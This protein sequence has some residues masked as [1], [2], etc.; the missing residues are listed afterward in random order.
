[1]EFHKFTE[2]FYSN[3]NNNLILQLNTI[4]NYDECTTTI[5]DIHSILIDLFIFGITKLNLNI[6]HDYNNS[7][8]IL[9][10]YFN[11][12]NILL[13]FN[14]LTIKD[15][16]DN[17]KYENRYMRLNIN[18]N[19]FNDIKFIINAKHNIDIIN[20]ITD[21]DSFLLHNDDF[22]LLINFKYLS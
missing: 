10:K 9:Q 22:N 7:I 4:N 14:K 15:L 8:N 17:E 13:N 1:M 16:I 5:Y 2:I 18:S 21:I 11:K 6:I 19:K 20:K 3:N 12:I